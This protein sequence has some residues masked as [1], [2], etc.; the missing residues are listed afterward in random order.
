[1]KSALIALLIVLAVA[2]ASFAADGT[3][4]LKQADQAFDAGDHDGAKALYEKATEAGNPDAHFSLSYKYSLP[5]EE[6]LR[7]Y[8]EAARSGNGKALGYALDM[9]LFQAGN[10]LR[11]NPDA[12]MA[13]YRE[14][15]KANPSLE[16]FDEKEVAEVLR[17]CVEPRGFDARKFMQTYGVKGGDGDSP[18]YGVWKLAEE[19]ST[20][21]R[22]GKPDPELVLNLV[23]RGGCVPAEFMS[24]VKETYASWKAGKVQKFDICKHITSGSGQAFCASRAEKKADVKRDARLDA[25]RPKLPE[26]ARPLA[27][28]AFASAEAFIDARAEHEEGHGGT[29]RS[30]QITDSRTSQMNGYMELLEKVATGFTPAPKAALKESDLELNRTYQE[31][32]KKAKA[33]PAATNGDMPPGPEDIRTVQRLWIKYRDDSAKCFAVANPKVPEEAWKS[34]LTEERTAQLKAIHWAE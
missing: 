19:A 15:K 17:M 34:W 29:A 16:L 14:A 6:S 3:D 13:L 8:S 33:K 21:G 5:Y 11:A 28:A 32:M 7:H 26:S 2:A 18:F 4:L 31:V 27:D 30:A 20:G 10:L 24:A 23:I 12:A 9:L 1:V 25:V 22:F